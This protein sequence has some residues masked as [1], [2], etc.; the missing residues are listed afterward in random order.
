VASELAAAVDAVDGRILAILEGVE[1]AGGG[2]EYVPYFARLLSGHDLQPR[3][4]TRFAESAAREALVAVTAGEHP[5]GALAQA[6]ARGLAV[7][8]QLTGARAKAGASAS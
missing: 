2:I 3:E 5:V 7:G 4:V 8:L 1:A 6:W